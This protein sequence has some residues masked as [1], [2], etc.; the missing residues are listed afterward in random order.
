MQTDKQVSAESWAN[1]VSASLE[2]VAN[3]LQDRNRRAAA[4][5]VRAMK[6]ELA[7]IMKAAA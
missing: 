4:N 5:R 1:T 3:G 6:A 7:Q 2:V